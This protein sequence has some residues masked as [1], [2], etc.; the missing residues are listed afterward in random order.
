MGA[1]V[2]RVEVLVDVENQVVGAAV[3]VGDTSEDGGGAA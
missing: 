2:V 1:R 3:K